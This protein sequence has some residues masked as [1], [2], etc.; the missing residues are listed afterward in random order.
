MELQFCNVVKWLLRRHLAL[1][2]CFQNG[3]VKTR[4]EN[5]PLTKSFQVVA[6]C[7]SIEC[8]TTFHALPQISAILKFSKLLTS[9][10]TPINLQQ[11][12]PN[13]LTQWPTLS[14]S[15]II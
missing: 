15:N 7:S 12:E 13:S 8:Y 2:R 10:I 5:R 4:K 6:F 3:V 1:G 11:V 9:L 14:N